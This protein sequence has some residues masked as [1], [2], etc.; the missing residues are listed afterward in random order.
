MTALRPADLGCSGLRRD[1]GPSAIKLKMARATRAICHDGTGGSELG[2]A[3]TD[4][5]TKNVLRLGPCVLPMLG[6]G[7]GRLVRSRCRHNTVR[8]A[9]ALIGAG[10]PRSAERNRS[11]V[12]A[13]VVRH[14]LPNP[15]AE[16]FS[17]D[18]ASPRHRNATHRNTNRRLLASSEEHDQQRVARKAFR[19][20]FPE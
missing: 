18:K 2:V 6:G 10:L 14:R 1:T 4:S 7:S 13:L 8:P 15:A 19:M 9:G 20:Y 17:K 3:T 11:I 12:G 16:V 5:R